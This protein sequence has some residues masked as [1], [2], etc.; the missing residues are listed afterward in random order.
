MPAPSIYYDDRGEIH[1]VRVNGGHRINILHT[2]AGC[3]RSGDVHPNEQCDF[4]LSGKVRV[5]TLNENGSMI[6]TTYGKH[7]FLCIPR[8]VPHILCSFY[9]FY[10][11]FIYLNIALSK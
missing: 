3:L 7:T 9:R 2:R 8:G 1:N 6:S 5:W 10:S 4:V 11:C